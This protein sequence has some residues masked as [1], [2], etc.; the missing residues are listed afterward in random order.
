MKIAPGLCF[1]SADFE[2]WFS[3]VGNKLRSLVADNGWHR[4]APPATPLP[5]GSLVVM[6][7]NDARRLQETYGSSHIKISLEDNRPPEQRHEKIL[8]HP[9]CQPGQPAYS[10]GDCLK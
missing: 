5:P 3:H 4:I 2:L 9:R 7:V 8:L 6:D 10:S 1:I